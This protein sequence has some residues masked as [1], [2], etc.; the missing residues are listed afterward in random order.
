[1][2]NL[3]LLVTVA[4]LSALTVS[5][6]DSAK[7]IQKK[8]VNSEVKT[9]YHYCD[10]FVDIVYIA[11][12]EYPAEVIETTSLNRQQWS[13][14]YEGVLVYSTDYN[15]A[16]DEFT[17]L[18]TE[19][20]KFKSKDSIRKCKIVGP[21]TE[22]DTRAISAAQSEA[23]NSTIAA[24]I[25]IQSY[26]TKEGKTNIDA[27]TGDDWATFSCNYEGA[28]FEADFTNLEKDSE[29]LEFVALLEKEQNKK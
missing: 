4:I 17:L 1:M 29:Y 13:L 28:T 2:K 12:E 23:N 11:Y 7:K 22:E 16:S 6:Q 26:L 14:Y 15:K 9:E 25:L 10:D 21:L 8:V 20:Y 18:T 27:A 19:R 24:K 5:A 3:I